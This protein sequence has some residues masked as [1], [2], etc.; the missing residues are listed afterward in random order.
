MA[1]LK[2]NGVTK[3]FNGITALDSLELEVENGEF[4]VLLGPTGAGKTTTLRLIAGLEKADEGDI[5]LGGDVINSLNPADRDVAMVFQ[6]YTLYPHMTVKEN[7]AFPLKS[8]RRNFS[9]AE[10]EEMVLKAAK[11]LKIESK[12]ERKPTELSGGEMQRV[13]IGRAIVRNPR[14]FLMD[15]PLS[16]LDAKLRE[17]MRSE[18]A[19]L[20][21]DMG[22]TFIY[23]THDQVEAMTMADRIGVLN[24]GR[25]MQIGTPD[26]IY[27]KPANTFVATFVGSPQINLIEA[28]VE[29]NE[30]N[31]RS[32]QQK[33]SMNAA[34]NKVLKEKGIT[35]ILYGIRPEEIS[36]VTAKGRNCCSGS[37]KFK[38][39][40]GAE[41]ILN[42]N[43]GTGSMKAI[44]SPQLGIKEGDEVILNVEAD[45]SHL[46]DLETGDAIR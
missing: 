41:D 7:L 46:F 22:E 42:L 20:H 33:I 36:V 21:I 2:L 44:V 19:R 31:L 12:L 11:T 34:Q 43:I 24:E 3:K 28:E 23:V 45:R 38:Q 32:L 37:V 15:E 35:K 6:Y 25:L 26:Q 4:F 8:R 1:E 18:L 16:N 40:M 39:S 5:I 17:S 9:E 13:G 27:N 29:G 30:L 14:I 10:I